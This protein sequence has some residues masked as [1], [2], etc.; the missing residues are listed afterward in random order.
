MS[1]VDT[2]IIIAAL[3]PIDSRNKSAIDIL[4][5][6]DYKVISELTII[7]LASVLSRR[8]EVLSEMTGKL[9]LSEKLTVL[10]IIMYLMRRFNLRYRAVETGA[11]TMVLGKMYKPMAESIELSTRL[12]LKTLDLLHISYIKLL[13]GDGEP[14][15]KLITADME[16][17]RAEVYLKKDIGVYLSILRS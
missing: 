5:K 17:G 4:E 2:S 9:G 7:E 1:Y 6:E 12:K 10:A 15:N 11:E 3:D 14:I 16:F 13:K 8:R